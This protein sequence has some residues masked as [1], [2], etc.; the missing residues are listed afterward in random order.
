MFRTRITELFGIEY[1]VLGGCM[2]WITGPEFTAAVSNAGAL[3]IMS[4]AMFPTQEEFRAALR[5]LKGLTDRSFAVNLNLFPALRPIDNRLYAEVILEEGGVAAVETS[6]HRPP[7][8]IVA[9]LKGGGLKLMHKC[10]NV[11][12]ALSAQKAGVDAVTLFGYEGGGHIGDVSTLSLVPRAV[13]VLDV[14]VIAAGGI[15]DGRGMLAAFSLGAEAVLL[16]TRLLMT[17]EC[18]ISGLVKENLLTAAETDTVPLLGSV[19]NTIRVI[20]NQAA[21]KAAEL[22]SAGADFQDI[23]AIVAGS[24]TRSMLERGEVDLG[25]L[26]CSQSVGIIHDIKTVREVLTE[27]VAEAEAIARRLASADRV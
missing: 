17:R 24:N 27:M 4:S 21:E 5:R 1:P 19:H 8:D 16:G 25:V 11:R 26:A 2:Q 9:M 12:H 3:G 14:P 22:E 10:V 18:P 13:D 15:A 7:E 23:L 6:G 20:R